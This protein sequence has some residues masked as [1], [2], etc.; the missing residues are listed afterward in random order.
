MR[1]LLVEDDPGLSRSL[2]LELENAG[3]A[4]DCATDGEA[5]EFLARPNPTTS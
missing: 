3:F 1:L 5:A 4:V 2:K